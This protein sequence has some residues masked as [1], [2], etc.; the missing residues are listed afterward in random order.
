MEKKDK[1]L[2]TILL[3]CILSNTAIAV[4]I[5]T[6]KEKNIDNKES[7]KVV[8]EV[9]DKYFDVRDLIVIN[10]SN[11]Y[12]ILEYNNKEISTKATEINE[13]FTWFNANY[14]TEQEEDNSFSEYTELLDML[15]IDE[16]QLVNSQGGNLSLEQLNNICLRINEEMNLQQEEGKS[17]KLD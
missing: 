1:I 14:F 5:S 6:K 13:L 9:E 8:A 15:T 2:S 10:R 4:T 17:L 7:T 11:K 3:I 12:F 16:I